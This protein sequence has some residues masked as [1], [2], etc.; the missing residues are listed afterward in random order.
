MFPLGLGVAG[1]HE[2]CE[3]SFGDIAAL[4]GFAI[5]AAK[6]KAGTVVWVSQRKIEMDHGR[7]LQGG[8]RRLNRAKM[9]ILEVHTRKLTD[10]LWAIEEAIR[11]SAV[12][13]VVADVEAVEFTAS[14]RLVLASSRHG[15]P[16]ILLQPYTCEG[17]TA[18]SARWRVSARPSAPNRFDPRAPGNPRWRARLERCRTAPHLA[19]H[20]FDLELN[21][22][23]LSLTVVSGLATDTA[24]TR[25]VAGDRPD[26]RHARA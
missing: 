6:Q 23:T 11:S 3:A 22:E 9:P 16:V 4:T 10:T 25:E 15:V 20:V 18:A 26:I 19:G 7:V 21:H 13:L 8:V 17:S 14:R 24:D 12:S 2:V 1:V 5:A